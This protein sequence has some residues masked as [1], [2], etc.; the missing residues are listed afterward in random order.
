MNSF[1]PQTGAL[2][3][4]SLGNPLPHREGRPATLER[5]RVP[6]LARRPHLDIPRMRTGGRCHSRWTAP[7]PDAYVP[8]ARV[9]DRRTIR[10]QTPISCPHRLR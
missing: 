4:T 2:R 8:P 3:G 5:N 6:S 1:S 7:A 9:R 10:A